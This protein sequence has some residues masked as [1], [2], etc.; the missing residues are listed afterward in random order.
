MGF[1]IPNQIEPRIQQIAMAQH[2]NTEEDL[3]RGTLTGLEH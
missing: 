1:D 3:N 2:I